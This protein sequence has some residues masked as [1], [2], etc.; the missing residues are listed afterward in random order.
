MKSHVNWINGEHTFGS[1]KRLGKVFNPAIGEQIADILL[2]N[3]IDVDS[4]VMAAKKALPA[5]S[6][7]S[8]IRRARIMFKYNELLLK[9]N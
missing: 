6:S 9:Q 8:P 1:S 3:S 2:S 7:L 4:A 5:W